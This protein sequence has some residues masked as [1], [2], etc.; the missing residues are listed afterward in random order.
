M[1]TARFH[2]T[3]DNMMWFQV[4]IQEEIQAE[5][6]EGNA[7]NAGRNVVAV[8]VEGDREVIGKLYN[9][10]MKLSPAGVKF[11]DITFGEYEVS[12]KT[13]RDL[14]ITNSMDVL[15][16]LME[17]IEENT[18]EMNRKL[19][20]M[21]GKKTDMTSETTSAFTNLFGND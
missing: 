21:M 17:R 1:S 6:I 15:I 3:G 20:Q 9:N 18:R 12:D 14:M 13:T 10:L 16:R 8:I 2:V 4:R 5:G 19:E 7:V 11:S